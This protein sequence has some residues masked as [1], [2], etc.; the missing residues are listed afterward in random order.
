MEQNDVFKEQKNAL[1][2]NEISQ[3]ITCIK[4]KKSFLGKKITSLGNN[5]FSLRKGPS[6]LGEK[7]TFPDEQCIFPRERPEYLRKTYVPN[8][9]VYHNHHMFIFI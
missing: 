1:G 3:K 6:F 2:T 5:G 7:G 9:F 4:N 8:L